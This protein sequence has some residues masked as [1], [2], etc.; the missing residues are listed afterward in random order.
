MSDFAELIKVA[1]F[2]LSVL[3]LSIAIIGTFWVKSISRNP[4]AAGKIFTPGVIAL[5]SIE[6]SS[7][8]CIG[9]IFLLVG[10]IS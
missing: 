3:S 7:L 5:A 1:F 4:E 6:V 9:F 2:A 10:K 8:A